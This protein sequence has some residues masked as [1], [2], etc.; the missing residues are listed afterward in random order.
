M[1]TAGQT[2]ATASSWTCHFSISLLE[3][4]FSLSL[5]ISLR[6]SS[7]FLEVLNSWT[8]IPSR[9]G[10][11]VIQDQ[12]AIKHTNV[13]VRSFCCQR[14]NTNITATCKTWLFLLNVPSVFTLVFHRLFF[15][16]IKMTAV[17]VF[18]TVPLLNTLCHSTYYFDEI[19]LNLRMNRELPS[20]FWHFLWLHDWGWLKHHKHLFSLLKIT[21]MNIRVLLDHF[22][23][24]YTV[25]TYLWSLGPYLLGIEPL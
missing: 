23:L 15:S 3:Y 6:Q 16:V 7:A 4:I 10:L 22:I 13:S 11:S 25:L 9:N 1:V 19:C 8:K 12:L 14:K 17:P 21:W 24:P 2:S 20:F 5:Y 18:H